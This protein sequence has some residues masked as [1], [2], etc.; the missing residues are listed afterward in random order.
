MKTELAIVSIAITAI[1]AGCANNTDALLAQNTKLRKEYN[2]LKYK[3]NEITEENDSLKK[4]INT[5]SKI[6][7]ETRQKLLADI[8]QIEISTRSGI[9]DKNNDGKIDTLCVYLSTIDETGQSIKTPGSIKLQLWDLN[10]PANNLLKE[11]NITPQELKQN[12]SN[13]FM[14][15]YYRLAYEISEL[16]PADCKELTVKLTFTDYIHGK[17]FNAQKVIRLNNKSNL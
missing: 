7:S 12:W 15:H 2:D 17:E 1:F 16:L 6:D 4:Q 8:N 5:L 13:T 11:W 3:F 10:K 9:F 14:T